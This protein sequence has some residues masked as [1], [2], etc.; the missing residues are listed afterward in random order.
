MSFYKLRLLRKLAF[1]IAFIILTEALLPATA[2]ALTAGPSAPEFSTF[3]PVA[4]SDMVNVFTGDLNYNLPVIE[5]PGSDGGGYAMSLS[6]NS[7]VSSEEESS[8][9]G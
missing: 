1:F 4:T 5:I 9:V 8:W 2:Y 7:G 3:T 6:Y